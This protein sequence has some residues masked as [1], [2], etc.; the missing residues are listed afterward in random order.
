MHR[1]PVIGS[2]VGAIVGL[3]AAGALIYHSF[4]VSDRARIEAESVKFSTAFKATEIDKTLRELLVRTATLQPQSRL[5]KRKKEFLDIP[6]V[7][8]IY[9][10]KSTIE[11]G[12]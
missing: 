2:I 9:V 5:E 11:N 10:D 8:F 12:F 1:L 6:A 7:S 4:K 3:A